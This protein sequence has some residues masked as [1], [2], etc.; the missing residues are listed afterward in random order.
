MKGFFQ[1]KQ[2]KIL[3]N[4]KRNTNRNILNLNNKCFSNGSIANK[5]A[6][7]N[8]I[9]KSFQNFTKKYNINKESSNVKNVNVKHEH[10]LS[11][12]DIENKYLNINTNSEIDEIIKKIYREEILNIKK[13]KEF[14][15]LVAFIK[16]CKK[17]N[18]HEYLEDVKYFKNKDIRN[19]ILNTNLLESRHQKSSPFSVEREFQMKFKVQSLYKL[20]K[21][22]RGEKIDPQTQREFDLEK[23]KYM[24]YLAETPLGD[25]ALEIKEANKHNEAEYEKFKKQTENIIHDNEI[26]LTDSDWQNHYIHYLKQMKKKERKESM[27]LSRHEEP[28]FNELLEKNRDNIL[29]GEQVEEDDDDDQYAQH[30]DSYAQ[31]DTSGGQKDSRV[32]YNQKEYLLNDEEP[33]PYHDKND[34]DIDEFY[35]ESTYLPGSIYILIINRGNCV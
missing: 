23:Y 5:V 11:M 12:K 32:Y 26:G 24:N 2:N 31:E 19:F 21:G 18:Y 16:N 30:T 17:Y 1:I 8:E 15:N 28:M 22:E 6:L 33:Y 9:M 13:A 29:N 20:R 3:F 35:N 27:G 4:F 14:D 7:E 34:Y 25:S 10:K